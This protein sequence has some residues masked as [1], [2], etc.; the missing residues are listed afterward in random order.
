MLAD[1]LMSIAGLSIFGGGAC[2]AIRHMDDSTRTDVRYAITAQA[3]S[4][5][6]VALFAWVRVDLLPWA[7]AALAVSTAAV[8]WLSAALWPNGSVP[9][10]FIEKRGR[11]RLW[12][13]A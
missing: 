5:F 13:D 4:G 1:V 3:V 7:V 6:A 10:Q 8:Q 12:R 11:S 9:H 2:R